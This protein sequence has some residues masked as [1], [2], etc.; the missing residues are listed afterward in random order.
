MAE[1]A[2]T[3]PDEKDIDKLAEPQRMAAKEPV[4]QTNADVEHLNQLREDALTQLTRL[5]AR[6]LK[7]EQRLQR[8]HEKKDPEGA[9]AIAEVADHERE[10]LRDQEKAAAAAEERKLEMQSEYR[11]DGRTDKVELIVTTPKE[12]RKR[13]IH[14]RSVGQ[15][16]DGFIMVFKAKP[17]KNDPK[18][19]RVAESERFGTKNRVRVKEID[20]TTGKTKGE[21]SYLGIKDFGPLTLPD[22]DYNAVVVDMDDGVLAKESFTIK[23]TDENVEPAGKQAAK[24]AADAEKAQEKATDELKGS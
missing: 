4:G 22:G 3:V 2:T 21:E 1:T 9:K 17:N 12:Q 10:R 5:A 6:D 14:L 7:F 16:E 11:V 19:G 23:Y 8:R 18:E 24:L 13:S 20:P 15:V